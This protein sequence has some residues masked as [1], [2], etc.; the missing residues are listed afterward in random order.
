LVFGFTDSG[1]TAVTA[2]AG[3]VFSGTDTEDEVDLTIV[4]VY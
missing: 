1:A 2:T 3:T 4:V